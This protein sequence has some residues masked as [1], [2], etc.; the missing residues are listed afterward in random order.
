M[1]PCSYPDFRGRKALRKRKRGTPFCV[2]DRFLCFLA[3]K[4]DVKGG[5]AQPE[6][7]VRALKAYSITEVGAQ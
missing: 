5:S 1:G 7:M 4:T 2:F 6:R 3:A